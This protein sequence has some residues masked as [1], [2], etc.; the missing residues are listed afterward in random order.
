MRLKH[1]RFILN[2]WGIE[3][4][5]G[6]VMKNFVDIIYIE[7]M[8]NWNSKLGCGVGCGIGYLYWTYEELKQ[9]FYPQTH[10]LLNIYIEPMRNWN[11]IVMALGYHNIC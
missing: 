7:P 3:T 8:R 11:L 10:Q 1:L 2:L 5:V 6:F 4:R 9:I